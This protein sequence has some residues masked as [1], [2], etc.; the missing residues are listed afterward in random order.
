VGITVKVQ[1]Y[2]LAA[3]PIEYLI[4][5]VALLDRMRVDETALDPYREVFIAG[6]HAYQQHA[7]LEL[8]RWAYDRAVAQQVAVHQ[9]HLLEFT[10]WRGRCVAKAL[11]LIERALDTQAVSAITIEGKIEIPMEMNVALALLLGLP[12]SPVYV[13][14]AARRGA[15]V[16]RLQPEIDWCLAHCLM[17]AREEMKATFL[18]MF[19]RLKGA[20]GD[21]AATGLSV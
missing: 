3:L 5:Q 12:D 20:A 18:P 14:S 11:D 9:L 6:V 4:R 1:I 15:Q 13:P 8:V 7:Y 2:S 16:A 10:T 19:A 17:C 21:E